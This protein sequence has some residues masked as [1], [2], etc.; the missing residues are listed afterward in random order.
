MGGHTNSVI[1]HARHAALECR[2]TRRDACF[3]LQ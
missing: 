2:R 3:T 1:K